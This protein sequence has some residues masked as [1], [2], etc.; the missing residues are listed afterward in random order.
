MDANFEMR[1]RS[2]GIFSHFD[3]ILTWLLF[4]FLD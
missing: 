2:A 1:K 4:Y 3:S